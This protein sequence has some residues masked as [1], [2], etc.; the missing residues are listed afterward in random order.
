V[1]VI[2][3]IFEYL[4]K[5]VSLYAYTVACIPKRTAEM[6]VQEKKSRNYLPFVLRGGARGLE[7]IPMTAKQF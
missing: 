6:C 5:N 2:V 4:L 3:N 7:P 1:K